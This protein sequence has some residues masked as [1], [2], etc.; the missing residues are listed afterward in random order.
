MH[1]RCTNRPEA[2][3]NVSVSSIDF[4]EEI[5]FSHVTPK[6]RCGLEEA[7]LEFDGGSRLY[8][9]LCL[10]RCSLGFTVGLR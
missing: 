5:E 1:L 10:S 4:I 7:G 9:R 2:Y 3:A 8:S 6:Q